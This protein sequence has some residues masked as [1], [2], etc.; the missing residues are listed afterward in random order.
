MNVAVLVQHHPERAA[1]IEPL[2]R[3]LPRSAIVIPDPDPGSAV[4][5]ALRTYRACLEAI[6]ERATHALV[7]QDDAWPCDRFPSRLRAA[8]AEHPDAL[9]ALFM[10]GSGAHHGAVTR[11]A[12]Q[13]LPWTR[14][15]PTWTPTVA[16]V[17]TA[18]RARQFLT[19]LDDNR[20]DPHNRHRGDDGPVGKFVARN[21]LRVMAPV[22]SLVQHPDVVPSLIGRRHAAG[23]NRARVASL[24]VG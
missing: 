12:K 13:G 17:W 24:F 6:P 8:V 9:L 5:S 14:V 21:R 7:I 20:Y 19:W 2:L 18:D 16:L 1:L 11:A 22:P 10:P 23:R 4:R 15:P 3:R